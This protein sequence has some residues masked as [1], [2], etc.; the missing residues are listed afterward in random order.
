VATIHIAAANRQFNFEYQWK[1]IFKISV[2]AIICVGALLV[3]KLLPFDWMWNFVLALSICLL[4]A[5][6]TKLI[7]IQQL[8]ALLKSKTAS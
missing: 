1:D 2:F 4:V 6:V 8:F 3:I 5:G 7:P